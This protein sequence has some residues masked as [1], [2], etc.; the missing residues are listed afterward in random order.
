MTTALTPAATHL[1]DVA[2]HTARV[3][4]RIGLR[5]ASSDSRPQPLD[6]DAYRL[7]MSSG[8]DRFVAVTLYQD[9]TDV[10]GDA[11]ARDALNTLGLP[12]LPAAHVNGFTRY[13]LFPTPPP[14]CRKVS[15]RWW[16]SDSGVGFPAPEELRVTTVTLC[17]DDDAAVHTD[18]TH[19]PAMLATTHETTPDRVR[20]FAV[21]PR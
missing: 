7:T 8:R 1:V 10:A 17:A 15:V 12:M 2:F 6:P 18:E 20:I 5:N 13:L 11:R 14:E 3:L 4:T 21:L 9:P 19:I 16:L